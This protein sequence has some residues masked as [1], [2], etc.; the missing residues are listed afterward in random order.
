MGMLQTTIVPG[1]S[2]PVL[3]VEDLRTKYGFH[4]SESQEA[5]FENMILAAQKACARYMDMETLKQTLVCEEVFDTT[6]GQRYIVL[7]GSPLKSV[8]HVYDG[9]VDVSSFRV[10]I[11]SNVIRMNRGLSGQEVVV[12]YTVGWESVPEDVLYCVA[13]TVQV[14]SRMA[15]SGFMGKNSQSTEGGSET[16]EQAVVPLA[17]RQYLD[18]YRLVWMAC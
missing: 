17:V 2:E 10:S 6:P 8:E 1:S 4:F 5:F 7:S 12:S 15:N 13:M 11:K 9:D 14:M 3:T 16:I 18:R